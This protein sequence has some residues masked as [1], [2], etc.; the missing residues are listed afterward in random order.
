MRRRRGA[1]RPRITG[2]TTRM[3]WT[4]SS[5]RTSTRGIPR[6]RRLRRPSRLARR[7]APRTTTTIITITTSA[8]RYPPVR[9]WLLPIAKTHLLS[10]SILLP[11]PPQIRDRS[12]FLVL[13]PPCTPRSLVFPDE[14]QNH[15]FRSRS[16]T[17]CRAAFLPRHGTPSRLPPLGR[18][19]GSCFHRRHHHCRQ[20]PRRTCEPSG[21]SC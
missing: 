16:K 2:T 5:R 4:I 18:R 3:I 21:R 17:A 13:P 20:K 1:R 6:S 14:P 10:S 8:T 12:A 9:H 11:K 19:G 7:R 15:A